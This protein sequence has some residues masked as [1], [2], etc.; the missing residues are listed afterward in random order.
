MIIDFHTHTFPEKIAAGALD[1]MTKMCHTVAHTKGTADA[2]R[3]SMSKAGIDLSIVLPVATNPL[4]VSNINDVSIK[5]N[6][7]GGE[8]FYFACTHPD[9][10]D[11]KEELVRA[12]KNGLKGVKIHP[13]YQGVDIDD[14]RYLRILD[15][16]AE[17]GLIVVMHAGD[18]IGF[19]GKINCSPKMIRHALDQVGDVTLVTAHM[20]GW[21]NWDS[22]SE[23]LADTSVYLDTAISIGRLCPLEKDYYT[24]E[25]LQLLTTDKFA[26]FVK[27]FSSERILFGTDSPWTDQLTSKNLIDASP[28]SETDKKNI[29]ENNARK[30]L[31]I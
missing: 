9:A 25:Q 24:E 14:I 13:V 2:L 20:G 10:P 3:E 28:I 29:F 17:L 11:W 4:K 19:P 26:E 15:K 16:C 27:V 12:K 6:E 18:D 30:L 22:V 21:R 5:N 1:K 23:Y 31:N 7:Q 8:L